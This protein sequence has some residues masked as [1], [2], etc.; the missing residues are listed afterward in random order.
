MRS[1]P[2]KGGSAPHPGVNHQKANHKNQITKDKQITKL[3]PKP[4]IRDPKHA[5]I[6]YKS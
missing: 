5:T 2:D 6:N 1:A 4:Q 3:N